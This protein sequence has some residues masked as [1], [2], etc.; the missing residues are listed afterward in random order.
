M[1][2]LVPFAASVAELTGS[3]DAALAWVEQLGIRG[4]AAFADLGLRG[5]AAVVL[6]ERA[7]GLELLRPDGTLNRIRHAELTLLLDALAAVPPAMPAAPIENPLVFT[8]PRQA[9]RLVAPAQRLDLLVN[10]VIARAQNTLHIGGPFWNAGGWQRLRPVI[11]PALEARHVDVTFYLHPHESGHSDV[12][13]SMLAE[14][15][16][17]GAVKERWWA[18]EEPSLM[19]A[20]FIVADRGGGYFG[21][22]NLT[23]LGLAEHLE[24]GVALTEAQARSLLALLQALED[25]TLFADHQRS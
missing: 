4:A 13:T 1:R 11:L 16:Q 10:D 8:V 25:A 7:C 6:Q 24:V 15:R 22:A 14:A 12:V 9:E 19:H 20:K 5:D 23:S 17:H 2:E 3:Y 21:S 18:S